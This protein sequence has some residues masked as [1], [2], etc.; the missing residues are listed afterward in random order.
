VAIVLHAIPACRPAAAAEL[1]PPATTY[2]HGDGSSI[3]DQQMSTAA[4]F[5][6]LQPTDWAYQ[7]LSNLIER[8]GCVAGYPNGTY[9]GKQAMTRYEAAALLNACLDRITDV[10]DELK[11]LMKE[12]EKELAVLKGRVDGLEAKVA[13]LEATQFSTTTKLSSQTTFVLGASQFS[14]TATGLIDRS[15]SSFGAATFNY[16]MRLILDTSFSG[17]DLLRIRLRAGNFDSSSNS[18]GGAGPS[19]LSQLEVAFQEQSGPDNIGVNRLYYQLPIG[20]FTF[21]LGGRVEQDNMVAIWPSL[22]P[23]DTILDLM[24]F[25]G[26][27]GANDL[28]LGVGAGVWWKKYGFA[29]STNYVAANGELGNPSDGGIAT[30]QSGGTGT[31]QIGYAAKQWAIAATYSAIQN[32][33]DPIPYGTN[34]A[35]KSFNVPGNTSAFG[36]GGY[37]QPPEP[38]WI[39]SISAGWGINTTRYA[40]KTDDANLVSETQSWSVGLLWDDA[41]LK[42]NVFGMAVG[43]AIFATSLNSGKTPNDSNY[44]WEWWYKIRLTDHVALVPAVFYL[45]RPLG[46]D[47]PQGRS[48]NQLGAL[49]KTSFQF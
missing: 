47:T 15:Q 13:E 23:S 16:D 1:I 24:T 14:G 26:S 34:F 9:R 28:D 21:T 11:R 37:W 32:G 30:K 42:G 12:F 35:L 25:G 22:Y 49:I 45:N 41:L 44:V 43:Q 20:D 38:G 2:G 10:T 3:S 4:Q 48:F 17:K 33:D 36:L 5:S 8:Y 29:I 7:A 19:A 27:I 6:D 40:T 31:L 46:A 39:P 18:F